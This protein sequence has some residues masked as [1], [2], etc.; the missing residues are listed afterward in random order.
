MWQSVIERNA[1]FDP[2]DKECDMPLTRQQF[3]KRNKI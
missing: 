1:A 3:A 2:K